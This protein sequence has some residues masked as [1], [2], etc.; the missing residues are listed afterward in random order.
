M[1]VTNIARVT[2]F[3][4]TLELTSEELIAARQSRFASEKGALQAQQDRIKND[5]YRSILTATDGLELY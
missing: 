1:D 3:I 2:K 4:L 5:L